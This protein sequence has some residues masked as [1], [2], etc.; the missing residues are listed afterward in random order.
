MEKKYYPLFSV[1]V[2]TMTCA[3]DYRL[4]GAESPED[5]LAH[6]DEVFEN[7][8]LIDFEND[9]PVDIKRL[10]RITP[11]PDAYTT[12]PY[13]VIDGYSYYE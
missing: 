13:K 10:D 3:M 2:C 11:I 9:D 12:T 1:D 5:L 7:V 6:W 4:V 8:T